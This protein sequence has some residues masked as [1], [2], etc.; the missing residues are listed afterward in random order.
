MHVI[1]PPSQ[2]PIS[3]LTMN[4]NKLEAGYQMGLTQGNIQVRSNL[5]QLIAHDSL[6]KSSGTGV[7]IQ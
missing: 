7:P 4:K 2:F 1:A 3:R 6:D 5:Q